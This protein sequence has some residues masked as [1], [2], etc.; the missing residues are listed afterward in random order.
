MACSL[1]GGREKCVEV[2]GGKRPLGRPRHSWV[3]NIKTNLLK[4][5]W[6]AVDWIDL[7]LDR[8]KWRALVNEA[9]N[10]RVP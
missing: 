2:I 9:I 8:V 7:A 6:S 5:G 3:D 10:L 1:D 4:I